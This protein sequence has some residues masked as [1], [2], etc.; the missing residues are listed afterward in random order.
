[1]HQHFNRSTERP[2]RCLVM[3][4]KPMYMFMNMLFQRTI[5]PFS[6][7]PSPT[8]PDFKPRQDPHFAH[9]HDHDHDGGDDHEHVHFE[10]VIAASENAK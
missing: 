2:A 4:T 6:R 9:D 1:V 7:E 10:T 8:A 5:V 3:K